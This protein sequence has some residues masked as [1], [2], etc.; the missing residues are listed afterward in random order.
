MDAVRLSL[1]CPFAKGDGVVRWMSVAP[2]L[3]T[4]LGV[5]LRIG[6]THADRTLRRALSPTLVPA[7]VKALLLSSFLCG[8][9]CPVSVETAS[10]Q[11]SALCS[12]LRQTP[13]FYM[14]ERK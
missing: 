11:D 14:E 12:L 13:V 7:L 4:A 6:T 3:R 8:S 10:T 9:R 1:G 2:G 5:A